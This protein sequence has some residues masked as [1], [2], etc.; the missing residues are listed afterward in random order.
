MKKTFLEETKEAVIKSGHAVEQVMFVGSS[1]GKRRLA[2]PEFAK[3]ADFEYDSGF[4]AQEIAKDLI[5]YFVDRT[6]MVRNEYDGSEWW[7]Y[8]VPKLFKDS[9][10]SVPY[11]KLRVSGDQVGWRDLEEINK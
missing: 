1:D 7:E 9:D 3:I 11:S 8:S 2:W 6:Y 10:E 4:G 5:V